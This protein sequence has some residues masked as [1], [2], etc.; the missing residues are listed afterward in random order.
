MNAIISQHYFKKVVWPFFLEVLYDEYFSFALR[1][2]ILEKIAKD[3]D[4]KAMEDLNRLNTIRNC[5]A[6]CNLEF[7]E[8]TDLEKKKEKVVDPRNTDNALDFDTLCVEF[9]SKEK[10]G[11]R[12]SYRTIQESRRQT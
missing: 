12:V 7:F 9:I 10:K 6:H 11:T 3:V 5:F 1:R 2:R 8:V 4:K